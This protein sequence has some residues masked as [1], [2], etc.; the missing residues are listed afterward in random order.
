[1]KPRTLLFVVLAT[2]VLAASPASAKTWDVP[3]D[4]P[5]IQ[6]AIDS[7]SVSA[8]DRIQ[9]AAGSFAGALVTKP[10][11]I[12]GSEGTIISTGPVHPS[13]MIQG[14]R[15]FTA[16]SGATIENL[17]FTVDLPIITATLNKV[18]NVTVTRNSL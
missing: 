1:M 7:P 13:K 5:T 6:A 16:A 18:D 12:V 17:T 3:G 2:L 10:V 4:F 11:E 14:F 8:G 9:V 15:L